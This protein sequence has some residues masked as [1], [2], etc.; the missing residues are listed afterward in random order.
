MGNGLRLQGEATVEGTRESRR[1]APE[2]TWAGSGCYRRFGLPKSVELTGTSWM[3][4]LV[5]EPW[6]NAELWGVAVRLMRCEDVL[7]RSSYCGRDAE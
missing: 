1:R 2:V 5:Y 7:L 6:L 3:A 4:S